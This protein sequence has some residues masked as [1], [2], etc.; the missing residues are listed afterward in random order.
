MLNVPIQILLSFKIMKIDPKGINFLHEIRWNSTQPSL[1]L[2]VFDRPHE[3]CFPFI[4]LS[5][6]II[7]YLLMYMC[8]YIGICEKKLNQL[9]NKTQIL[10]KGLKIPT[11]SS[12]SNKPA[13]SN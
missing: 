2:I 8:V 7:S 13:C 4:F 12:V 6:T 11:D 3:F 1:I 5:M 9:S 10:L